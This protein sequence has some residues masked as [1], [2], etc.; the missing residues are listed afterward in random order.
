MPRTPPGNGSKG[1]V[2][3][4]IDSGETWIAAQN[5]LPD[6]V[7]VNALAI[8]PS[9]PARIYAATRQ[10]VFR[11]TD[12]AASWTPINSGLTNL[13][14]WSLSIDGTGSLLRAATAAGLFEYQPAAHGAGIDLDQDGLT[15]SW[16]DP[17]TS[18]QGFF[19][20]V[21]PDLLAPGKGLVQA[22]WLT[23]D[24]RYWRSGTPALV[25]GSTARW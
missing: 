11:S 12:G 8:D 9:A 22:S 13:H 21:Y 17:R 18:G 16:Y 15:G 23:Y 2:F 19:V 1:G 14:V 7:Y 6:T 10:G 3:K 4:S 20:Q 25:H 5:G 24:D